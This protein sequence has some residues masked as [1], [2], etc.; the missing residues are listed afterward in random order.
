MSYKGKFKPTNI[1][2]YIGNHEEIVYRSLWERQTFKW[3]DKNPHVLK[4][5]SEEI[6][7]PYLCETDNKIHRYF[8][9]I[10]IEFDNGDK[11]LVEIKPDSQTRPPKQPKSGRRTRR[12]IKES[13]T[14]IRN[15]SK[16]KSARKY[17]Q[18][19][20]WKFVIWTE[21][22]LKQLGIKIIK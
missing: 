9:D 1:E 17:A 13:M 14:Y 22:T 4:W 5:S 7:V 2:K 10:Y 8:T 6:I 16:W 15:Q 21:K 11:Y 18:E 12:Y 3:L 19:R 20:G